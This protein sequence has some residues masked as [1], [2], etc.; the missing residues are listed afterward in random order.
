M[1]YKVKEGV[2]VNKERGE[3]TMKV[4]NTTDINKILDDKIKSFESDVS[5]YK[6]ESPAAAAVAEWAI[7]QLRKLK[8]EIEAVSFT[9]TISQYKSS[10]TNS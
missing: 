3:R 10:R 9:A 5:L 7:E 4:V 2:V 8:S 6:Y 1:V